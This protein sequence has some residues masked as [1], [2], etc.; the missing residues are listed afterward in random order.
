MEAPAFDILA[1]RQVHSRIQ[2]SERAARSCH[3]NERDARGGPKGRILHF[4][5]FGVSN[6]VG[7]P[8]RRFYHSKVSAGKGKTCNS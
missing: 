5:G 4:I 6:Q 3:P 7:P 2:K 1:N 8:I